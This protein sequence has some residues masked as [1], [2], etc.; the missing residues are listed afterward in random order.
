V[1]G[2]AVEAVNFFARDDEFGGCGGGDG[3]RGFRIG[4]IFPGAGQAR[5][6]AD[7]ALAD[8]ARVQGGGAGSGGV[9]S[10]LLVRFGKELL[11]TQAAVTFV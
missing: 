10:C 11:Q 5:R 7:G 4:G 9:F 2:H 3:C 1:A 6:A 8:E